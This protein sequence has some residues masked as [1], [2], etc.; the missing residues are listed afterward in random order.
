PVPSKVVIEPGETEHV[1]PLFSLPV[2][3]TVPVTVTATLARA[4]FPAQVL[5]DGPH[6]TRLR[7]E[8]SEAYA[9]ESIASQVEVGAPA[10]GP[11]LTVRI[12]VADP[13]LALVPAEISIPEG[14]RAARFPIALLEAAQDVDVTIT[15]GLDAVAR[16]GGADARPRRG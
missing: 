2:A 1:V 5:L 8:G 16:R 9:G 6:L 12:A 13:S 10:P 14:A 4:T 15:A 7:R 3:S 11:G